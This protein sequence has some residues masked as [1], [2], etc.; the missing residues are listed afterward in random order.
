MAAARSGAAPVPSVAR[1]GLGVTM[2]KHRRSMLFMNLG[3]RAILKA[4][5]A[6]SAGGELPRWTRL[7]GNAAPLSIRSGRLYFESLPMAFLSEK[8]KAAKAL[9]FDPKQPATIEPIHDLLKREWANI[10]KK[11]VRD[12]LMSLETYQRNF[13]RARPVKNK[14]HTLY[15]SPGVIAVDAFFPSARYDGWD[16]TG[17]AMV[18]CCMDVWSR[19]SRAYPCSSKKGEVVSKALKSFLEEMAS[20]GAWPRRLLADK[21]TDLGGWAV[22]PLMNRYRLPRDKNQDLVMLA[23]TGTPVLVIEAMNAQYQRRLAVFRTS[24][25]SDRVDE[26]LWDISEQLNRQPRR[27][28]GNLSPLELLALSAQQR[29][30]LNA[31]FVDR[32]TGSEEPQKLPPIRVGSYVRILEMTRKEQEAPSMKH[33]G[34][35]PKWSKAVHVVE[36]IRSARG[37]AGLRVFKLLGLKVRRYRWELLVVPKRTDSEVPRR[38]A[39]GQAAGVPPD[40]RRVPPVGR[41]GGVQRVEYE[42]FPVPADWCSVRLP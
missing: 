40:Q 42:S 19:F 28:R 38:L 23:P 3:D 27:E 35:R 17:T 25:L 4:V 2:S 6:L 13:R 22:R 39:S 31:G 33:K 26:I 1:T 24:G 8:R 14:V 12:A 5:D 20:M 21:G 36:N 18:L 32:F 29:K 10:T 41:L 34:F 11:N 37:N 7:C 30:A 16:M 15:K 9:Y